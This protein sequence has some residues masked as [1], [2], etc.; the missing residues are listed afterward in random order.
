MHAVIRQSF[1]S[2]LPIA[3]LLLGITG[4]NGGGGD[5]P[6]APAPSVSGI[7]DITHVITPATDNGDTL[8]SY[9]LDLGSTPKDV[10]FVFTNESLNNASAPPT[11]SANIK[12]PFEHSLAL[13]SLSEPTDIEADQNGIGLMGR[14]DISLFNSNPQLYSRE[15]VQPAPSFSLLSA[16]PEPMRLV[17]DTEGDTTTFYPENNTATTTV[18]TCRKVVTANGKTLNIWVADNSW[19]AGCSRTKCIDQAKIDI[20]ADKFLL[21]GE[22]N[23]VYE[24]LTNIFGAEWGAHTS[25][26]LITADNNIT[27]LLFD[28]ENDNSTN[29]GYLGYF[30]A[31][32]NFLQSSLPGSNERIMFYLDSVLFATEE[33]VSWEISDHWPEMIL[34]ALSHEFQHMVHFYQKYVLRGTGTEVWLNEMCSLVAE[35]LLSGKLRIDGPRGVSYADGT[36]GATFNTS[37]RL[38]RSN[39]FNYLPVSQWLT[40]SSSNTGDDNVLNSYAITYSFGA[41]LARNFGGAPLFRNIVQ[42]A[43]GDY[44]AV[45]SALDA[46][47]FPGE[48]FTSALK[49]WGIAS[50]LSHNANASEVPAGYRFN[51]GGFTTSAIGSISYELGSINLYNYVF[52]DGVSVQSGPRIY[53]TL[54]PSDA[55]AGTYKTSNMFYRLGTNLTGTINTLIDLKQGMKFTVLVK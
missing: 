15:V 33:G 21:A 29:G 11:L 54:P 47:G 48:T 46:T 3:V 41:F 19:D 40:G 27:I 45:D 6:P 13:S 42:N 26:N 18:A 12:P 9:T 34:S 8:V 4:C 49:K 2:L 43:S 35:D 14:P 55:N 38:P 32:D 22:S 39:R 51:T 24:W 5:S 10:D 25:P 31:K 44:T 17:S 52:H 20:L 28:L 16:L 50:L 23:D 1:A 7:Y 36:A 53:T 37:G 30:Y